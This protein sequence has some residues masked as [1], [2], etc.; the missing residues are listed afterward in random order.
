MAVILHTIGR[1]F[2]TSYNSK[3]FNNLG[4]AF[5]LL[6]KQNYLSDLNNTK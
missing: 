6:F 3:A 5:A 4:T 1:F 2:E